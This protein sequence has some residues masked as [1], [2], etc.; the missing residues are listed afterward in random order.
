L[1]DTKG[2]AIPQ[3]VMTSLT[4]LAEISRKHNVPFVDLCEYVIKEIESG[5]SV[6]KDVKQSTA[7]A[8]GKGEN[9]KKV[10]NKAVPPVAST[11]PAEVKVTAEAIKVPTDSK[12]EK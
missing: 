12:K 7:L 8:D 6:K 9:A 3:D 4:K 5:N 1:S 2:V 10:A 11:T